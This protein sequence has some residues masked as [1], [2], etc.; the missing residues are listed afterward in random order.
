MGGHKGYGLGLRVDVLCGVLS[1]ALYADRVYPWGGENLPAGLGHVFGAIRVDAFRPLA[2]FTASMDDLQARLKNAPKAEG[3][4]R[5]YIHG[6]KE[7][8]EA[9]RRTRDGIPLNPKVLAE[10]KAIAADFGVNF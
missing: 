5:I 7:Y 1:G 2:E 6:E 3:Q 10:L 4:E 8:E 9:E